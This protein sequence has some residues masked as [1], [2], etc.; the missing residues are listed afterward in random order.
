MYYKAKGESYF[1]FVYVLKNIL[2]N[3]FQCELKQDE[4]IINFF[5]NLE[6]V[7]N[8]ESSKNVNWDKFKIYLKNYS[9]YFNHINK[10]NNN[11][12]TNSVVD[13]EEFKNNIKY[14][15]PTK[16]IINDQNYINFK[17]MLLL[18]TKS[19]DNFIRNNFVK[20]Q[21]NLPDFVLD[22]KEEFFLNQFFKTINNSNENNIDIFQKYLYFLSFFISKEIVNNFI[23]SF[24]KQEYRPKSLK[25][26]IIKNPSQYLLDDQQEYDENKQYCIWLKN[27]I[28]DEYNTIN[29]EHYDKKERKNKQHSLYTLI[30]KVFSFH[31]NKWNKNIKDKYKLKTKY[32]YDISRQNIGYT[33]NKK[34]TY[35]NLPPNKIF[36]YKE[37]LLPINIDIKNICEYYNKKGLDIFKYENFEELFKQIVYLCESYEKKVENLKNKDDKDNKFQ[38]KIWNE[39]NEKIYQIIKNDPNWTRKCENKKNIS[40]KEFIAALNGIRTKIDNDF[41]WFLKLSINFF[42]RD[43][44]NKEFKYKDSNSDWKSFLKYID[45]YYY[46]ILSNKK[47][48]FANKIDNILKDINNEKIQKSWETI[49]AININE[50][51]DNNLLNLQHQIDNLKSQ[52]WEH[53]V[54]IKVMNQTNNQDNK[55][56]FI[57]DKKTFKLIL[58]KVFK[59][60]S[61]S[62]KKKLELYL[63]YRVN[64]IFV[65]KFINNDFKYIL[66]NFING[67]KTEDDFFEDIHRY[68]YSKK[69]KN[70]DQANIAQVSNQKPNDINP[71][72]IFKNKF[73]FLK[74]IVEIKREKI[75]LYD[76]YLDSQIKNIIIK[77]FENIDDFFKSYGECICSLQNYDQEKFK[78]IRHPFS[79]NL[80]F[81][82]IVEIIKNNSNNKNYA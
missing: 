73:N 76:Q 23:N 62:F 52:L 60:E 15:K 75:S 49:K 47:N 10:L 39:L 14:L 43:K 77:E 56:K 33:F 3:I 27:K 1:V 2:I 18:I 54:S 70:N 42:N 17:T 5:K 82:E 50:D 53:Y 72:E 61:L 51:I 68:L 63:N 36:I 69:N 25:N 8:D 38:E 48:R 12:F 29:V 46:D 41:L 7:L 30:F 64:N 65:K 26:E 9:I 35:S 59:N 44:I 24:I 21:N 22:D 81:N 32:S 71:W 79:Y 45:A 11:K 80:N 58:K 16:E 19:W 34:R 28:I 66:N 40:E 37:K 74:D 4:Y 55:A 20:D 78:K 31:I 57:I 67:N 13:F 6:Q